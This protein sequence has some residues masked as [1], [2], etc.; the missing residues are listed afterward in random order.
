MPSGFVL[1][2]ARTV[3]TPDGQTHDVLEAIEALPW[4]AQLCP[5]MRHEYTIWK[6]GPTWAW[7]V[8]S[9]MLSASNPDSFR[10]YFRGY[11]SA[12][13]YWDAP[14][15]LRYW[16]GGFEID[17][18]Q[19]DDSGLRRVDAGAKRAMAWAGPPWAPDSSGLSEQDEKGRWWPTE[20]ALEAGYQPCRYC[21]MTNRKARIVATPKDP[22]GA[23]ALIATAARRDR[24]DH[25]RYLTRD[26]LAEQLSTC[27]IG[28][29]E[30]LRR[31]AKC[32]P[33]PMPTELKAQS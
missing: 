21:E 9:S 20:A 26:E 7:N 19:P 32:C 6:K 18:G 22:V 12:N 24:P 15:G 29:R 13:R 11:R 25:G 17:R 10:A 8:L 1:V 27:R 31:M 5:L 28:Y 23:A 33:R 14:D 2:D 3:R 30:R 16:R 4:T